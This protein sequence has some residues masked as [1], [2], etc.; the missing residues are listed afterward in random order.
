MLGC[1]HE[2]GGVTGA[3]E[4]WRPGEQE[5]LQRIVDSYR[6]GEQGH[7]CQRL[8]RPVDETPP[9][10]ER[11]ALGL[12]LFV[13]QLL[14]AKF[15]RMKG[16][17]TIVT[18]TRCAAHR[19]SLQPGRSSR[20]QNVIDVLGQPHEIDVDLFVHAAM[21]KGQAPDLVTL[22]ALR[23]LLRFLYVAGLIAAPLADAVPAGRGYPRP[24]LPRAASAGSIRAVLASCDRESAGETIPS[25]ARRQR[26]ARHHDAA[27]A[28]RI[29]RQ[30]QRDAPADR[31]RGPPQRARC[32]PPGGIHGEARGPPRPRPA[33]PAWRVSRAALV[34]P[35]STPPGLPPAPAPMTQLASTV[36]AVPSA[37]LSPM[38]TPS[39]RCLT[40]T[41]S[42]PRSTVPHGA[43]ELRSAYR[44]IRHWVARGGSLGRHS[45]GLSVL[46][47]GR[48][49]R[50]L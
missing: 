41:A 25:Y 13:K 44:R 15:S 14:Q 47:P 28:G 43:P 50:F 45:Y 23:S 8:R 29:H 26:P 18:L 36:S 33:R 10:G 4:P 12:S 42:T 39:S 31:V 19:G 35:G 7:A 6:D 3:G 16:N 46:S 22:P 38:S 2:R 34:M 21:R 11:N 49:G 1:D 37:R 27:G 32:R 17:L 48:G 40:D 20:L 24:V 30:D 9:D 5:A